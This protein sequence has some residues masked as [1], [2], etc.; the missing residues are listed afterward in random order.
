MT[1]NR[2]ILVGNWK[3]NLNMQESSLLLNALAK[4]VKIHQ[5]M[6][7]VLAPSIFALQSL[8]LQINRRQFKLAAQNFFWRDMGSFT[9]EV[10]I[11]QLRGIV[12]YAFVGHSERRY[13]FGETD[14]DVRAKVQ[15]SLRSGVKPI[16]CVGETIS[17]RANG[18]TFD[19]LNDQLIGGLANVTSEEIADVVVAYEPV[20]AIG[21][22]EMAMPDDVAQAVKIIRNQIKELYGAKASETIRVIYG[23]SVTPNSADDYLRIDGVD[24]LFVGAASLNPA[25]FSAIA[26][27]VYQSMKGEE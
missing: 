12:D 24:G 27:K 2:P 25:D 1:K 10:S 26:E 17:E 21:S 19:A 15:A 9:G 14:R 5:G 7:V 6:D 3:M 4:E 20:W 18:E 13:N 8:S 11:A 22:G 16:L 23:G